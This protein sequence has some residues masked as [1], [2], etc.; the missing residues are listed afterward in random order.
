VTRQTIF[1]T[2][3][4]SALVFAASASAQQQVRV[5]GTSSADQVLIK[6]TLQTILQFSYSRDGCQTIGEV[7]PVVLNGYTLSYGRT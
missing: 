1:P 5:T 2:L 7:T 4:A 6:D 3:A